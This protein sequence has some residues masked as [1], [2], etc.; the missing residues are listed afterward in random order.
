MDLVGPY[1][2]EGVDILSADNV[3]SDPLANLNGETQ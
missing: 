1:R 3:S 2:L